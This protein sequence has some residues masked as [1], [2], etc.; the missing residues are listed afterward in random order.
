MSVTV[1]N[2][3]QGPATLYAAVFGATEPAKTTAALTG[4][5]AVDWVD[6]GGTVDG[7]TWNMNRDVAKMSVDQITYRVGSRVVEADDTFETKLA[8]PTLDNLKLILNGGTI[9]IGATTSLGVNDYE[10]DVSNSAT[11]MTYRALLFDGWAPN[12][13]RRRVIVRKVCSSDNAS[14]NY[15]RADQSTFGVTLAAHYVSASIKPFQ[16]LD[17]VTT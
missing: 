16:V 11:Q 6:L 17:D 4:A 12:G 3:I 14:F 7:L 8:E 9:T 10:P 1:T 2:L 13:K 5:P 15:A